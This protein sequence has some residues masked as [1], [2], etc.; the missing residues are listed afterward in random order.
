MY[1][2]SITIDAVIEALGAFIL[3]FMGDGEVVRAQVN[4]VPQPPKPCAVLTELRTEDVSIPHF[5]YATLTDTATIAGPKRIH[6]QIDF[7]GDLAGDM[8]N[9][10]KIAFRSDYGFLNFPVN[11]KPLYSDEG[12]QAQMITGERQWA[13]RWTLTAVMQY[14]PIVTVPQ[15]FAD[16]A[17]LTSIIPAD[18]FYH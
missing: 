2:P 8:C 15:Q 5:E 3:P 16:E 9:A 1:T 13:S 7:Y 12:I 18:I 10:V 17:E 6:V 14:N 11:I 4:R